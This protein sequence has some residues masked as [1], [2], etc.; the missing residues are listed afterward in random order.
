MTCLN[1]TSPTFTWPSR[2]PSVTMVTDTLVDGST[3]LDCGV[4]VGR[5]GH[6]GVTDGWHVHPNGTRY[7]ITVDILFLGYH[8]PDSKVHGAN[9]V[10]TGPRWA[11]CWPHEPCYQ[12]GL[13][14][15]QHPFMRGLHWKMD[16]VHKRP[17][18]GKAFRHLQNSWH[19][20]TL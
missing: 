1:V 16:F 12:G 8:S 9:M 18:I 13:T 19:L 2:R 11:P 5:T 20:H 7:E 10:P 14:S 4:H 17:V 6:T 15:L 3:A